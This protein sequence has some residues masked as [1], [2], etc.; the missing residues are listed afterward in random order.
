MSNG[1]TI[2]NADVTYHGEGDEVGVAGF[3]GVDAGDMVETAVPVDAEVLL[4]VVAGVT[5][6]TVGSGVS[7][8]LAV[9][10]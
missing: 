5:D 3:E 8:T 1:A 7:E 4:T 10:V 6:C 2:Q 9:P